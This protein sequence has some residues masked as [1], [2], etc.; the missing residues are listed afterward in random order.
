MENDVFLWAVSIGTCLI[1]LAAGYVGARLRPDSRFRALTKRVNDCEAQTADLQSSFGSLL[2]SH[3][4]LRSRIGM[5]EL[6]DRED[7]PERETKTQVRRRL[8]GAAAGP[9]F[10]KIQSG[11][12]SRDDLR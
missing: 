4:R 11:L 1:S 6:R 10:A 8:F 12:T 5:R 3:K 2:E 9:A 7:A